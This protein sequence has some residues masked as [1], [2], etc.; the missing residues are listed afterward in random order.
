MKIQFFKKLISII[1]VYSS[2]SCSSDFLDTEP[3][4]KMAPETFYTTMESADMAITTCYSWFKIEKVWDLT[5]MMIMGSVASDEAETGGG[6]KEN[7]PE[8]QAVDQLRHDPYTPKILEWTWGYLYQAINACNIAIRELPNISEATDRN[9]DA[10]LLKS[11]IAEAHFLRAFN[12][13]YLTK[14]FGGVPLVD[15]ILVPD[16]YNMGRSEIS[17]VYELIK[18]D[19]AIAIRDLPR[20]SEWSDQIG[21]ASKEAAQALLAKLYLFESSY[22]K[23]CSDDIRFEGMTQNWDSVAYYSEQ[24]INS[25]EFELVGLNGERF[26]TWRD[27]DTAVASTGG[28]QYI[29]MMDANNSK[30]GVFEIQCRNDGLGW[31]YSRGEALVT[32]CAPYVVNLKNGST[33]YHGWGWW[34]PSDFLVSQYETGDPRYKASV[35]EREDSLL[36]SY[37]WVTPNFDELEFNTGNHR[38]SR[39]YECSPDEVIVGPSNWSMGPINIKMIRFADVMLWAAEAYFEMN[40]ESKSLEYINLVRQRARNSGN[41]Q[42]AV[43]P[44]TSLTHDDIVHE[45][46]VELA[47]EGHRFFDLVRWNLAEEYLNHTLIDGDQIE[48]KKGMHE[49]FPIPNQEILQSGGALEQYPGWN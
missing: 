42:N 25:G 23:Y 16:E 13:F 1:I 15:H 7:I 26:H 49:F 17:E 46:L 33:A 19:L 30:E 36:T 8:F 12:F 9:Y 35:L 4:G 39:K 47:L 10:Q 45:R 41:D 21:R 44:L 48:F 18:S 5:I 29:F 38:H 2:F 22:A 43:P 14:I 28:Y 3:I 40:N 11:R 34:C 6:F 31:F 37:G 27:A 20:K 32:W 24:V